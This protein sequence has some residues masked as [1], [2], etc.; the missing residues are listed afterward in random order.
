MARSLFTL[1]SALLL[2]CPVWSA[3]L[4]YRD[5]QGRFS[6]TVPAGWTPATDASGV[7]FTRGRAYITVLVVDGQGTTQ[8]L[9]SSIMQ[10]VGSKW[11]NFQPFDPEQTTL[12]GRPATFA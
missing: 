1:T 5:P 3:D 12:G 10:Q 4:V 8:T 6:L 9:A 11:Q 2:S 7:Q